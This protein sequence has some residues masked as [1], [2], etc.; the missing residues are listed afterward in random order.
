MNKKNN[1][2]EEQRSIKVLSETDGCTF[3][4]DLKM[5]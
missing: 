3:K 5:T 4:P 2:I 1:K